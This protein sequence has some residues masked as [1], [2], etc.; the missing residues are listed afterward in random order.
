M[1]F[2][3]PFPALDMP[4]CNLLDYLFPRGSTASDTPLWIDSADI[5]HHLTPR[6]LLQ[7]TKRLALGLDRIGSK[8]GEVVMILTPNHIFVPV[9]YLGIVGSKRIF[10]GANPAYTVSEMIH[11]VTNTEAQFILAHPS[12]ATTALAAAKGAGLPTGRVFMFSDELNAPYEGCQDWRSFLPSEAE[13]DAYSFPVLSAKEAVT[14]TATVNFSS[15]TT[16][17]PKGVEVS[18]HN[19]IANLDQTIFMRYLNKP[20]KADTRPRETWIGFLPLYHAYGQLYTI[21]MA[22]KLQI[23]V[24][25]MKKFEY[26]PFLRTIQD[27][28][29]THLQIAPPIMVMLSKRPETA[30]YDLSS[31][32]DILCGAAPLSK[33]LQNEISRKLDCE[34]VQGWGMTEVTCGA[35]HVPGGTV[36]DSGSVGQL[37]PNCE[38]MLL[39]DDG[40]EVPDGQPGEL[41]VRGPNI[42]LGYWRNPAATKESITS[43]GWLKSGD[44]AIVKN[45]WF[46]IVD[47]KKELIKVNALQVAPAELEAV[48]LE[49]DPIADAAA[50]G[51][52]LDG[53]EWPRAYVALKDDFKGKTTEEDI[54]AHMKIKVAKHKQLVGGIVFVDEV[55]KLQSGKIMRKVIKD[56]A[57]R[58]AEKMNEGFKA[59]L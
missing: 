24:Y 50:V 40:K 25:I 6:T 28:K 18:H 57:K 31:V 21:A 4:K 53:Q 43:D 42:C 52:T 48:L 29:V 16:G 3:S 5:N 44:V 23:P 41:H 46:W 33:E 38:C 11:Q 20:W 7:W 34:I 47:R 58:D 12:L 56:W 45:G 15:G 35:I 32:T 19:I 10:S 49:F 13:G 37:D 30:K 39:D 59:K 54:H 1:P 2:S 22:Q 9:A 26:E 27:Q 8:P 51:I 17:I 36:D 14:T 55:P